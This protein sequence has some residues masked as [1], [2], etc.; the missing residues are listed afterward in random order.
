[1][2]IFQLHHQ[3]LITIKRQIARQEDSLAKLAIRRL[4]STTKKLTA[5]GKYDDYNNI[6]GEWERSGIIEEVP[7]EE[8]NKE[9]VHYLPHRA[10]TKESSLTTKLRPVYDASAKDSNGMSLNSCLNKGINFLDKIPN[11]LTGFCKGY[12]DITADI[13]KAFLQIYS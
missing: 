3:T 9:G 10:V 13:A 8:N 11:L 7:V 6:L 5:S 1:M 2:A 12:I 4:E